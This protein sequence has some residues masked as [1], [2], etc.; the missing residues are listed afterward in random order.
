MNKEGDL[1]AASKALNAYL[2]STY[3]GSWSVLYIPENQVFGYFARTRSAGFCDLTINYN[4]Q[5]FTVEA[6]WYPC[7]QNNDKQTVTK[8]CRQISILSSASCD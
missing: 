4:S 3:Y 8:F 1:H 2:E 7:W 5:Q 6:A